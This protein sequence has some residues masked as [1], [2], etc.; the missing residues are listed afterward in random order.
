[1]H[2]PSNSA[3]RS[4]FELDTDVDSMMRTLNVLCSGLFTT[5]SFFLFFFPLSLW[6]SVFSRSLFFSLLHLR[7][8]S[9]THSMEFPH[10]HLQSRLERGFFKFNKKKTDSAIKVNDLNPFAFS[11]TFVFVSCTP[12]SKWPF[13]QS[14]EKAFSLSIQLK[15]VQFWWILNWNIPILVT[16]Q[17]L[18]KTTTKT[19]KMC[20]FNSKLPHQSCRIIKLDGI[21][22][23]NVWRVITSIW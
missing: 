1:M 21:V 14:R 9:G 5:D 2:F 11:S 3:S 12:Y 13:A 16:Y 22:S 19:T 8:K 17:L 20:K 10:M 15:M 7:W 18:T 23:V 4:P 6:N